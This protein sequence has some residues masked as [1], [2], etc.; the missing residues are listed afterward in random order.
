MNEDKQ[1]RIT[2]SAENYHSKLEAYQ[3]AKASPTEA[4]ST[5]RKNQIVDQSLKFAEVIE[6][7]T[8]LDTE[9]GKIATN[10]AST[11]PLPVASAKNTKQTDYKRIAEIAFMVVVVLCGIAYVVAK[12]HV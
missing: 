9:C 3:T 12:V 2:A 5:A 1:K 7:K 8:D 4:D 6:A 11:V 10:P